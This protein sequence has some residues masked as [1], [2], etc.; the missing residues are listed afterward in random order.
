[1]EPAT[2][3]RLDE[4]QAAFLRVFLPRLSRR[5]A[6][7]QALASLYA[8]ALRGCPGVEIPRRTSDSVHH[9]FVIRAKRRTSLRRYLQQAGVETLVHYPV[10]LHLHTAFRNCGLKAGDLPHTER[11]C[12]EIVSLPF[13]PGMEEGAV[14][15]VT[16]AIR[17]FYSG[18]RN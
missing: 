6:Q 11:A 4:L 1:M 3:A 14:L 8:E 16:E 15:R 10:P 17:A 13:W 18:R 9:L 2:N 7:R 12:R 5:N